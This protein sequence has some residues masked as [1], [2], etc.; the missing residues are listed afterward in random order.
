MEYEF[1]NQFSI[2]LKRYRR[3]KLFIHS[4]GKIINETIVA[5]FIENIHGLD[6][7]RET[8]V[9]YRFKIKTKDAVYRVGI[10]RLKK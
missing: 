8:S 10:K 5:L 4:I 9:H 7:I 6:S 3:D 1:T 2:D